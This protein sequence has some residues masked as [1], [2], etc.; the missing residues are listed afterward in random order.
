MFEY[1]E[2]GPTPYGE[3][4]VQVSDADYYSKMKVETK[5]YIEQLE[6]R[7]PQLGDAHCSLR[8][9]GFSHDFGTY[10]EV[11]IRYNE[12]DN[13]AVGFAYFVE[14]NLPE[15]WNDD[16]VLTCDLCTLKEE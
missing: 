14:S 10:H 2:L 4:C 8:V 1:L 13:I 6:K 11:C 9:K 7:F 3:E 15:F 5:K 12:D 16:K